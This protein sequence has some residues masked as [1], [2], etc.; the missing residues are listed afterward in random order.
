[1]V[2]ACT[3]QGREHCAGGGCA[4]RTWRE[5]HTE[6]LRACWPRALD[7]SREKQRIHRTSAHFTGATPP[8]RC[9]PVVVEGT[10][11]VKHTGNRGRPGPKRACR[12]SSEGPAGRLHRSG[13]RASPEW[14]TPGSAPTGFAEGVSPLGR[15]PRGAVAPNVVEGASPV[16]HT[17]EL[18][19]TGSRRA[20]RRW[21]DAP[22]VLSHRPSRRAHRRWGDAPTVLV[23]RSWRW[24]Y[25]RWG[26]GPAALWHRPRGGG[27]FANGAMPRRRPAPVTPGASRWRGDAPTALSRRLCQRSR[28]QWGTPPR[29]PGRIGRAATPPSR[30]RAGR[31]DGRI[32]GEA[33]PRG[34]APQTPG[35]PI[36]L[37]CLLATL[38]LPTRVHR[39]DPPRGTRL[40]AVERAPP[41]SGEPR[42]TSGSRPTAH[43]PDA[44]PGHT[45]GAPTPASYPSPDPSSPPGRT[46]TRPTRRHGVHSDC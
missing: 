21:G 4:G 19:P 3:L 20:C 42:A 39:R 16:G 33:A 46:P 14:L 15:R 6:G 5:R 22:T 36:R 13:L 43:P 10:S 35:G 12:H 34:P 8:R 44:R 45:P 17:P 24:A 2:T 23:H 32:A 11:P 40:S 7:R 18:A 30:G 9:A 29:A 38:A 28:R 31:H 25:R 37:Y 1:M 26:D 27:R 41:G